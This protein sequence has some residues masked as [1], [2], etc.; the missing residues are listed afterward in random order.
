M[1]AFTALTVSYMY[2]LWDTSFFWYSL[3]CGSSH[4]RPCCCCGFY[5]CLLVEEERY[6]TCTCTCRYVAPALRAPYYSLSKYLSTV[7]WKVVYGRHSYQFYY[8]YR[9]F[10]GSPMTHTPLCYPLTIRGPR[11]PQAP[12]PP[13][14]PR[15][16]GMIIYRVLGPRN[17]FVI[18]K[19]VQVCFQYWKL[20][21]YNRLCPRFKPYRRGCYH[22]K[23]MKPVRSICHVSIGS[24]FTKVLYWCPLAGKRSGAI[25]SFRKR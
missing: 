1:H 3:C 4:L 9:Y 16:R 5:S 24:V 2:N 19:R 8:M 6:S 13:E 10:N 22:S 21:I 12:R 23:I 11:G 14:A 18:Y 20:H 17:L 25:C 7:I 15:P